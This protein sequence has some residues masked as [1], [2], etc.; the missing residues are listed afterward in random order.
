MHHVENVAL[1][2]TRSDLN[3]LKVMLAYRDVAKRLFMSCL[4][5]LLLLLL[6]KSDTRN[7]RQSLKY[8]LGPLNSRA[9]DLSH[10]PDSGS[11]IEHSRLDSLVFAGLLLLLQVQVP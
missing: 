4:K 6:P 5:S 10:F 3:P 7:C 1:S 2:E 8:L 9:E 11:G